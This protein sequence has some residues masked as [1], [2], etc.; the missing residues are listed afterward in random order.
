MLKT[1]SFGSRN[2]IYSNMKKTITLILR[3]SQIEYLLNNL[4]VG[5]TIKA[6]ASDLDYIIIAAKKERNKRK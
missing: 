4:P 6:K 5:H 2:D 3:P 1:N